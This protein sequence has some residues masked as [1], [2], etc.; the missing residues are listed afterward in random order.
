MRDMVQAVANLQPVNIEMLMPNVGK[1]V[2]DDRGHFFAHARAPILLTE[3]Q[4]TKTITAACSS[5]RGSLASVMCLVKVLQKYR[6]FFHVDVDSYVSDFR[7]S[8]REG[9]IDSTTSKQARQEILLDIDIQE[10]KRLRNCRDT[11]LNELP[12]SVDLYAFRVD[13]ETL[14]ERLLRNVNVKIGLLRRAMVVDL[15]DSCKRMDEACSKCHSVLSNFP[16]NIEEFE[17]IQAEIRDFQASMRDA[18][19]RCGDIRMRGGALESLQFSLS[20]SET[21]KMWN[22]LAW[23]RRLQAALTKAHRAIP[24]YLRRFESELQS[25]K[26]ALQQHIN[27]L[28]HTFETFQAKGL[29]HW[30]D[31]DDVAEEIASFKERIKSC[32]DEVE[33]ITSREA[34]LHIESTMDFN[35]VYG[36]TKEI[37]PFDELWHAVARWE[38]ECPEWMDGPFTSMDRD[39]VND[40][41]R[42]AWRSMYRLSKY[43]SSKAGFEQ[44]AKVAARLKSAI[45]GFKVNLPLIRDLLNPDLRPRHW[46]NV[47]DELNTILVVDKS[48]TLRRLLANHALKKLSEINDISRVASKEVEIESALN[49][50]ESAFECNGRNASTFKTD[51]NVESFRKLGIRVLR[52]EF[53]KVNGIPVYAASNLDGVLQVLEEHCMVIEKLKSSPLIFAFVERV[54]R[55]DTMHRELQ[56]VVEQWIAAQKSYLKLHR[57]H[58]EGVTKKLATSNAAMVEIVDWFHKIS[59]KLRHENNGYSPSALEV[60]EMPGISEKMSQ[61]LEKVD[62]IKVSISQQLSLWREKYPRLYFVSDEDLLS[63]FSVGRFPRDLNGIFGMMFEGCKGLKLS[64]NE[65]CS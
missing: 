29:N 53:K 22:C 51:E 64:I 10:T 13:I 52:F 49:R 65:K 19:R 4:V 20:D 11:I 9:A 31:A 39:S 46:S 17:A 30:R 60:L 14:R 23:P 36:M 35:S 18:E 37:E 57:L 33:Q 59:D 56:E 3:E 38:R 24:S 5:V 47:S 28:Q 12:Q 15:R 63:L 32:A 55:M 7:K 48:M 6:E 25:Q 41:V 34:V 50:L 61:V 1:P 21:L 2:R 62:S 44:P 8:S 58:V 26:Q 45:E 16:K 27:D 42:E 40:Y 54:E 43:F